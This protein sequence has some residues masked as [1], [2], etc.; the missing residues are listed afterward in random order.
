MKPMDLRSLSDTPDEAP[1]RAAWREYLE[2]C[3]ASLVQGRLASFSD[4]E[5]EARAA[6]HGDVI[7]DLGSRALISASG[8]DAPALLQ[9][10]LTNDIEKVAETCSQLSAWCS[11]KGRVLALFRVW[12]SG[13]VYYLEMPADLREGVLT[14]LRRYVLRAAVLLED[15]SRDSAIR[16]GVSG[17]R[18][19]ECLREEFDP[20]PGNPDEARSFPGATIIRLRGE[21]PRF[22]IFASFDTATALWERCRRSATPVADP[23]WT[24]LDI[25]AGVASIPATL[26]ERFLPQM[27]NLQALNGLSFSKGCYS[28]Q[29]VVARAQYLGRLKRRLYRATVRTPAPVSPGDVLCARRDDGGTSVGSVVNA[30][31]S[32]GPEAWEMLAVLGIE[33]ANSEEVRLHHVHG[34]VIEIQPLP[35]PL[36]VQSA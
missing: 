24:L 3:G 11:V 25:R 6:L 1:M 29:E 12:R 4:V 31:R 27:L 18:V 13:E 17:P 8:A 36:D 19:T 20:L 2:R 22:Q 26:S 7:T 14:R 23:A 35:Y 16:I 28:G 21:T 5:S 30:E 9:G 34:P 10:Q 32:E 15:R 33:A